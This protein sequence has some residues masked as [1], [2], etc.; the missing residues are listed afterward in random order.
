MYAFPIKGLRKIAILL[1]SRSNCNCSKDA[2][3]DNMSM[4][5]SGRL[6]HNTTHWF[7]SHTRMKYYFD[8]S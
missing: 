7:N 3:E 1:A 8:M 6:K 2:I 4:H 5:F